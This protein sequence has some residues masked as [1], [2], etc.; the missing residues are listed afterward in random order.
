MH[1]NCMHA[2]KPDQQPWNNYSEHTDGEHEQHLLIL[3]SNRD[4]SKAGMDRI[5]V[6]QLRAEYVGGNKEVRERQPYVIFHI[7]RA[8]F[9]IRQPRY[10]FATVSFYNPGHLYLNTSIYL[11]QIHTCWHSSKCCFHNARMPEVPFR[12]KQPSPT[13][14]MEAFQEWNII[15]LCFTATPLKNDNQGTLN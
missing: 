15:P 12:G 10:P 14:C 4:N 2:C 13:N 3:S 5:M 8:R 1:C 11:C 7:S 6:S 9:K